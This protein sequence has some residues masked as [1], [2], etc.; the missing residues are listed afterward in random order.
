MEDV[1]DTDST[2]NSTTSE[3]QNASP[4]PTEAAV[5]LSDPNHVARRRRMLNLINRMRST[6][7]QLDLDLP[8]IAVIGSQSAGKSSLIESISGITLPRASGT[9]TRC[10]TECLLAHTS[11]PWRCVVSLRL[12]TD[13]HGVPLSQPSTVE[14]GGPIFSKSDVTDRIRRAQ[15]AIL[16]PSTDAQDFLDTVNEDPE[17]RELSFSSNCVC[18]HIAGKDV[19]DLSFVDLPG[20]IVGGQQ[21]EREL[22]QNLAESYIKKPSCIILLTVA[23][24]TD[25]ENQSAH[26]LAEQY[27]PRGFR[28]I[29]VLTKPDRIPAGEEDI[30]LRMIKADGGEKI[31]WYCIKN[32]GS[33]AIKGG[34]T[35]EE[36]RTQEREFF[37]QVPPWV[38]LEWIY[39]QRLGTDRLTHRLANTLT[40]LIT[41]R[42]PELQSEL[43]KLLDQTEKSIEKLP[44][45]PSSEPVGQILRLV[46]GFS[47]EVEKRTEGTSEEDGLL[48][49]LQP[50]QRAFQQAIRLTAPDFRPFNRPCDGD[51]SPMS[52]PL[53]F[54]SNEE[55]VTE[56]R[57]SDDSRAIYIDEVMTKARVSVTRELPNNYPFIVKQSM[58]QSI[59][60]EWR[61]PS[62]QLFEATQ[63][64]LHKHITAIVE[65]QFG[66]FGKLKNRVVHIMTIHMRQCMTET[67]RRISESLE[68]EDRPFSRNTHYLSDYRDKFLTHYQSLRRQES[69]SF[70]DQLDNRSSREDAFSE[71]LNAAMTSLTQMGFHG[72]DPSSLARLLPLDTM[73]PAIEIMADVRAY[74]Q[75]A[76]KRFVD[77]IPMKIDRALV[78]GMRVGLEQALF[79]GLNVKG[80]GA[81]DRCRQLLEEPMDVSQKREELTKRMQRLLRARDELVE[82][83]V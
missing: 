67:Q 59:V 26:R 20:L 2:F 43:D 79:D 80:P 21:N 60:K 58:I 16:N 33:K 71:A 53:G 49:Q 48:Q 77:V 73:E 47:R 32:P 40:E 83:F 42:L 63:S 17:Q 10:P 1:S 52:P 3:I 4:S 82:V 38:T 55:D 65:E 74:F 41:R 61:S 30:W 5:G 51:P 22:V 8:V 13:V 68:E 64:I 19:E 75:V 69:H 56:C 7:A 50:A 44:P 66:Q 24:E 45:A 34:I 12:V 72:V 29:G 28:T 46:G 81:F 57:P 37:S 54:L 27:D 14:F 9:C 70:V 36:S 6:G 78:L 35:W 62:R 18:L 11:E 31:D 15:L 25:F 39:S 76:Y 23:C